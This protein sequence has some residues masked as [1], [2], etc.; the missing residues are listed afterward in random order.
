ML[1]F[2]NPTTVCPYTADTFLLQSEDDAEEDTDTV[3]DA[4]ENQNHPLDD[5]R[6]QTCLALAARVLQLHA[7]ACRVLPAC[8]TS[9]LPTFLATLSR[10]IRG[11][12]RFCFSAGEKRKALAAMTHLARFEYEPSDFSNGEGNF[13]DGGLQEVYAAMTSTALIGWHL[14][15]RETCGLEK[16]QQIASCSSAA[17]KRA[18]ER[19]FDCT[20]RENMNHAVHDVG[21][22]RDEFRKDSCYDTRLTATDVGP[23]LCDVAGLFQPCGDVQHTESFKCWFDTAIPDSNMGTDDWVGKLTKCRALTSNARDALQALTL[24]ATSR[25]SYSEGCPQVWHAKCAHAGAVLRAV[26]SVRGKKLSLGLSGDSKQ[27]LPQ[28][29]GAI[30]NLNLADEEQTKRKET[31]V[32]FPRAKRPRIAN[33]AAE[34]AGKRRSRRN[35]DDTMR[36]S[37]RVTGKYQ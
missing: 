21:N 16:Q 9:K 17:E 5:T 31:P 18:L 23:C 25:G 27:K 32:G 33:G 8:L 22:F 6:L 26:L 11:P 20:F 10:V 29:P 7:N 19:D 3:R 30:T 15:I 37:V 12:T 36:Y 34:T 2:P 35:A 28:L 13:S 24:L 4:V 14:Y 1:C